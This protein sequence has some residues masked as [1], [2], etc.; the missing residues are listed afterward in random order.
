LAI[1]R[2]SPSSVTNISVVK[3]RTQT[4]RRLIK[5]V[6][7]DYDN[8]VNAEE[9]NLSPLRQWSTKNRNNWFKKLIPRARA[10]SNIKFINKLNNF[11]NNSYNKSNKHS[12]NPFAHHS[13]NFTG[14]YQ[15]FRGL[16]TK[17]NQLKFLIPSFL[18][19]Y[20]VF[21]EIWIYNSFLDNEFGFT[22][23]NVYYCDRNR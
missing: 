19:D 2:K 4:E 11:P 21:S 10:N 12:D 7:T 1:K 15:N 5:D 23:Y 14:Y 18:L 8:R 13:F 17:I 6:Y 22:Q 16:R 3:D 9:Q 20:L